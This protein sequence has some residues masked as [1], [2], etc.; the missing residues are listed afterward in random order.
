MASAHSEAYV[1]FG[2]SSSSAG[3]VGSSTLK[4][5]VLRR[6]GYPTSN[7]IGDLPRSSR[8]SLR[9]PSSF[10]APDGHGTD[11]ARLP[12]A[13]P[14]AVA[15]ARPNRTSAGGAEGAMTLAPLR[16]RSARALRAAENT[17]GLVRQV[18]AD[19][20]IG[21]NARAAA[22]GRSVG[23]VKAI[24]EAARSRQRRIFWA[25]VSTRPCRHV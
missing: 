15:R 5:S 24:G 8:S 17:K 20:A 4:A 23:L 6:V 10:R 16:R 1:C 7:V 22:G 3:P 19:P 21:A 9:S 25:I 2:I 12:E 14:N 18:L 13:G 11:H